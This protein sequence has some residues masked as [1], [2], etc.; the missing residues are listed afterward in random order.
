MFGPP[1]ACLERPNGLPGGCTRDLVHRF[2]QEPYQ[3]DG[4]K[5]DRY[6]TGSDAIGLTM[7]NYDTQALPIYQYLHAKGHPD[8]AIAD[9]FFQGAF[10]GSF[11]NHQWLIAAATPVW[12][13]ALNDG[14]TDDLHSVLDANGMPNNYPLYASPLGTA[15]KD[16]QLTQSC[17]PAASRPALQ[18]AFVCGNYAVNTTQPFNEPYSPGTAVDAAAAAAAATNVTIG[19]ELSAASVDWAWYSGGWDNAAGNTAGPAGR[20]ATAGPIQRRAATRTCSRARTRTT[21]SRSARTVCSSSTTSRSTTTRTT[22]PGTPGRAHLQDELELRAARAVVGRRPATS[23]TVSFIKPIGEENE[24][25]GYASEPTGQRP[26]RRPA[27]DDRGHAR[28]PRTRWSSSPTTSSADSGITSHRPARA[29]TTAR[30]TCG[31][32]APASRRSS[33]PRT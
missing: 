16:Q 12:A 23:S 32:R 24:H 8:Y 28:A 3:L 7:G 4:G 14:S 25:P 5:Q 22:R 13:G 26:P 30:T 11:L 19:D 29:T 9:D 20:T 18:P 21:P 33:L 10:G 6:V 1:T 31:A 27:V 2:Y 17:S 15:V